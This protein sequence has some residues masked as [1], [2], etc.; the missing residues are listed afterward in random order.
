MQ[1][2]PRLPKPPRMPE[3]VLAIIDAIGNNARTEI[4][5]HLSL[6]AMSATELAEVVAADPRVVR[7]HLAV[8][9]DLGLV[10]ADHPRGDRR[11]KGRVVLWSTDLA[12]AE[13]VGRLWLDYV[14][15]RPVP[16]SA[17]AD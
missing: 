17:S 12:R 2:V 8:L 16:G 6:R 3:G 10:V 15:G 1:R 14:A 5:R 11:A 13:E 7:R 4:L 9:E